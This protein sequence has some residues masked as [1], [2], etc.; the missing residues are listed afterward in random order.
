MKGNVFNYLLERAQNLTDHIANKVGAVGNHFSEHA[1]GIKKGLVRCTAISLTAAALLGV[2][3][4]CESFGLASTQY[5]SPPIRPIEEIEQTG[6]TAEDVLAKYDELAEKCVEEHYYATNWKDKLGDRFYDLDGQFVSISL[7]PYNEIQFGDNYI[8]PFFLTTDYFQLT[9]RWS[10]EP[11]SPYYTEDRD[12]N[13]EEIY[14]V[15]FTFYVNLDKPTD[16]MSFDWGIPK[17]SLDNVLKTLNFPT[18]ILVRE[19]LEGNISP[20]DIS[21]IDRRNLWGTKVFDYKAI[22]RN[23]IKNASEEQ[24][25]A[26]YNLINDMIELNFNGRL[27]ANASESETVD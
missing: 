17:T 7:V 21:I 25:W 9:N 26:L 24:L 13:G 12:F 1:T 11:E 16:T 23:L 20:I 14:M 2:L 5:D 18:R 3:A 22:D 19:E 15:L 10:T 4:G 27:P 6:I 8:L